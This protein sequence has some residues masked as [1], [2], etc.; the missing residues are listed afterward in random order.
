MRLGWRGWRLRR[1]LRRGIYSGKPL[2]FFFLL[3]FC[4]LFLAICAKEARNAAIEISSDGGDDVHI[5][6]G[7]AASPIMVI[8]PLPCE[9]PSGTQ[10]S[11]FIPFTSAAVGIFCTIDLKGSVHGSA[12]CFMKSRRSALLAG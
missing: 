7:C 8:R 3:F 11:S 2:W 6:I 12:S 5:V 1:G 9:S 10:S 4:F